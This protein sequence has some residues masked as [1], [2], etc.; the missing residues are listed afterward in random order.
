MA[1][2]K[3]YEGNLVEIFRITPQIYF[4]RANL[5]IRYQCNGAFIVGDTGVIIVD[6]PPGGLEM[7]EEAE[8]LFG[9]PITAILLTHGHGDHIQGLEDFL[10]HDDR[11]AFPRGLTVFCSR[12]LFEDLEPVRRAHKTAFISVEGNTRLCFSRDIELELFTLNDVL[13]SHWD[14]FVRIAGPGILCTG[15][16]VV[17]YETTHFHSANIHSWILSLG[18]LAE[19]RGNWVLSGH[20]P[21]LLPYSYIGEFADFLSVIERA[22]KNCKAGYKPNPQVSDKERY[23]DISTDKVRD[24]VEEFFS[25]PNEDIRFLEE[26]AG[27]EDARREVRMVLWEYI[28]EFI[29]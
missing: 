13:H 1:F 26:K 19:Q 27:K 8:K 17:E 18:R 28:R 15:D 21:E 24:L 5:K 16:S 10:N 9:K 3:I 2:E 14:M 20:S 23:A 6:A 29:R 11:G 4:R 7:A 25:K 12:H 22:A